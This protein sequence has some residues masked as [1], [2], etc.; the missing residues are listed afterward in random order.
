MADAL[1]LD[2]AGG[3]RAA[4]DLEFLWFGD[5]TALLLQN[6]ACDIIGDAFDK[7]GQ[8]AER[9][10]K[11]AQEKNLPPAPDLN[12]PEI[13]D[14]AARRAQPHQQR[15]QLAVQSRAARRRA[16]RAPDAKSC[17]PA[18]LLLLASDGFLALATDYGAY[19]ATGLMAAARDKGLAALGEELRAIENADPMGEKFA[20]FKKSDDAT[21]LA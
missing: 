14:A 8:E 6:E 17:A 2:D 15:Q 20:R 1:R 4:K 12:R 10:R 11:V 9:A 3:A 13:L 16:C 5:C 18:T 19:D 21:A 7:R